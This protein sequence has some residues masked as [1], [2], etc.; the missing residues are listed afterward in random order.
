VTGGL[1]LSKVSLLAPSDVG[2]V[3]AADVFAG[4]LVLLGGA[5]LHSLTAV[6]MERLLVGRPGEQVLGELTVH[7]T[8]SKLVWLPFS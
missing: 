7:R 8:S 5:V 1:I 3:F 4:G 6:A 2:R